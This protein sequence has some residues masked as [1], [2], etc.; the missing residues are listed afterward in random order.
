MTQLEDSE[1]IL[2]YFKEYLETPEMLKNVRIKYIDELSLACKILDYI[3]KSPSPSIICFWQIT[4][5][6]YLNLANYF[7]YFDKTLNKYPA[8]LARSPTDLKIVSYLTTDFKLIG[9]DY[10]LESTSY[11][12]KDMKHGTCSINNSISFNINDRALKNTLRLREL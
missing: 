3:F 5:Y 12:L 10:Y 4:R 2:R 11:R 8:G 1:K 6:V 7:Y 9:L